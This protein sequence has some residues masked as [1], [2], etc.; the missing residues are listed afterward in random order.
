MFD[1][2]VKTRDSFKDVLIFTVLEPL[3]TLFQ[4]VHPIYIIERWLN[5]KGCDLCV[6]LHKR[7]RVSITDLMET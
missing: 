5:N 7:T 2:T 3:L 1:C 6:Q 4:K